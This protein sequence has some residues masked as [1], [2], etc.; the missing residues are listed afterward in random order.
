M[1]SWHSG[2]H[3][4]LQKSF[5]GC[6]PA[7]KH[8]EDPQLPASMLHDAEGLNPGTFPLPTAASPF[9][10]CAA[11]T[12]WPH[13]CKEQYLVLVGKGNPWTPHPAW[14]T[15]LLLTLSF[16][17][18]DRNISNVLKAEISKSTWRWLVPALL[19]ARSVS[20][21][22]NLFSGF[23]T[24]FQISKPIFRIQKAPDE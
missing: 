15:A 5:P 17:V 7:R 13:M 19:E 4:E 9:P 14:R 1:G 20:G 12:Y 21:I 22:N 8:P 11:E 24:Y 18:S 23:K 6:S 3:L 10:A 16:T 2:S